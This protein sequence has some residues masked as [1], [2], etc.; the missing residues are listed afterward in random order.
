[1]RRELEERRLDAA[2]LAGKRGPGSAA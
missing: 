1:V 2:G